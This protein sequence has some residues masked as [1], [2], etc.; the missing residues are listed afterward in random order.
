MQESSLSVSS[1]IKDT[2]FHL[3]SYGSV[4]YN[5]VLV[6]P[7]VDSC[8]F[9]TSVDH[10]GSSVD[11]KV[12]NSQV[13]WQMTLFPVTLYKITGHFIRKIYLFFYSHC[14]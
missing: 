11:M 10:D 12:L 5:R 4:H 14:I 9:G 3:M 7:E 8:T 6:V 13:S 2:T 1:P